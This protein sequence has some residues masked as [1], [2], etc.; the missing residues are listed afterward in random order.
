MITCNVPKDGPSHVYDRDGRV[1]QSRMGDDGRLII[2][3]RPDVLRSLL[4]NRTNGLAWHDANPDA[5]ALL[6]LS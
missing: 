2:D 6:A 1:Y 5:L 3:L 4:G